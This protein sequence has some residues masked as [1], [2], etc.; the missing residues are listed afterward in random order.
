[1]GG[2]TNGCLNECVGSCGTLVPNTRGEKRIRLSPLP[3]ASL[4][5]SFTP[6]LL[7]A[8]LSRSFY[9]EADTRSPLALPLLLLPV[10]GALST[11]FV[12][13]LVGS[14]SLHSLFNYSSHAGYSKAA[15]SCGLLCPCMS[16][17]VSVC[18]CVCV[19]LYKSM[20]WIHNQLIHVFVW[21]E[22]LTC[23]ISARFYWILHL[24][25]RPRAKSGATTCNNGTNLSYV[26]ST[27]LEWK[28]VFNLK[29]IILIIKSFF[30]TPLQTKRW[31]YNDVII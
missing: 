6:A 14:G 12:L 31:C 17:S 16:A 3:T 19:K 22:P 20:Q 5:L 1:M 2:N 4:P 9:T 15:D 30:G 26:M 23:W 7:L 8:L 27:Y 28:Q 25:I 29:K 13:V 11:D 18:V 24:D 21:S 10:P